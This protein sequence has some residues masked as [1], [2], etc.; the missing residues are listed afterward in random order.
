MTLYHRTVQRAAQQLAT[1]I[2]RATEA[3]P[4]M[5]LADT[6]AERLRG[7]AFQVSAEADSNTQPFLR[8]GIPIE[9]LGH[10]DAEAMIDM[11]S[12]RLGLPIDFE[13]QR[14]F[15][16][17]CGGAMPEGMPLVLTEI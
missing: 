10:T 4:A 1:T 5:A 7:L 15:V 13:T 3:A 17:R 2:A 12:I 16:V 11:A 8:M 6:L 14:G 9:T